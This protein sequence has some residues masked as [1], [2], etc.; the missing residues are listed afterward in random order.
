MGYPTTKD[1]AEWDDASLFAAT[2]LR[3]ATRAGRFG[4]GSLNEVERVL[5]CVFE[6]VG[7]VSNGGFGQWLFNLHPQVIGHTPKACANV[8]AASAATLVNEVLRPLRCPLSFVAIDPWRDY[9]GTLPV[10][11]HQQ[12]E[13][14]AAPFAQVEKDLHRCV[15]AYARR[16][17]PE[18]RTE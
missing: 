1:V 11:Q 10:R 16:S 14:F 2:G 15:Y 7:E 9:L 6:L 5:C 4:F 13:D 18:V 12:F 17:W 8:G 3:A